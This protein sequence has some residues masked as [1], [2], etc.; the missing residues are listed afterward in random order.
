VV[1]VNIEEKKVETKSGQSIGYDKL[2]FATGSKPLIPSF[3]AGY[4]LPG[5]EYIHKSYY[6]MKALKEKTDAVENIIVIGGGF[7]GV[8][9]AEQLSKSGKNVFLVERE[10]HCLSK[11]FSED[12]C[13]ETEKKIIDSGINLYT[14]RSVE[15]I[16]G[17]SN[18]VEGVILDDGTELKAGVVIASI[19]YKPNVG[20]AKDAGLRLDS[21]EAI[22]VDNYL[23]TGEQDVYAVGDC[24]GTRGFITGLVNNV[25]LAS[26]ATAEARTLAYNLFSIKIRRN[27]A[28]TISVF[29]TEINGKSFASAGAI[30]QKAQKANIQYVLGRFQDVDRH[31]GTFKDTSEL[32]IKLVV[33]P[34]DGVILGG[35]ICGGKSVGEL[36]NVIAL[37]IQKSVTVYELIS[38]QIGT[39]PLLTG[40]PT[41]YALIK[42]AE[43]A[44]ENFNR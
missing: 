19:G 11:A 37:A 31:P 27:M 23:R 8:E 18:G 13:L 26:T 33:S 24:A 22:I 16:V 28:G 5:V 32:R 35:E 20:L 25:M 34:A 10:A 44:M 17:S 15:K 6:S 21:N 29:S 42:A 3:I 43:N 12:A 39:H 36:I 9:V 40:A 2:I 4:D 30:E 7:I 1:S 41:K 14:G 38:F